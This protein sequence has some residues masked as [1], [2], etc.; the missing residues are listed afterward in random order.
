MLMLVL[1][2]GGLWTGC[3]TLNLPFAKLGKTFT[4]EPEPSGTRSSE[5]NRL[6][7]LFSPKT[8]NTR[9]APIDPDLDFAKNQFNQGE[10]EIA[11]FYL[12]KTLIGNPENSEALG[13]LPWAYFYQKRYTKALRAFEHNHAFDRKDPAALIGMGWCYFIMTKYQQSLD[14][15]TRAER[16]AVAVYEA[17]KGKGFTYLKQKRLDKAKEEF[18]KIYSKSELEQL[19][20]V[21]DRWQS[22]NQWGL[23]DIVP[24]APDSLSLFTLPV[25]HPRY[26]STL[27]GLI[28][29]NDPAVNRA[30]ALYRK[31]SYAKALQAFLALPPSPAHSLDRMNGLAWS[32]LKTKKIKIAERIFKTLLNTHPKFTGAVKGLAKVHGLKQRKASFA[33]YY[34]GLG[35]LRIAEDKFKALADEFPGWPYPRIQLGAIQ[36]RKKNYDAASHYYQK[37]RELDPNHPG[38]RQGLEEV[39][40][41]LHPSLYE[42]G[43][44]LQ[45]G[46]FKKAARIYF[47][48]L[49][50]HPPPQ[51][52]GRT[53][54]H[55]YNGLGWSQFQK[56]HYRLA[57]EKF[58]RAM[59]HPDFRIEAARGMGHSY[60]ALKDYNQA[61]KYLQMV[62]TARPGDR[63]IGY[64]LDESV[65]RGWKQKPAREYFQRELKNHPLRASPYMGLGWIHYRSGDPDLAVE[66]FLKSISLDPNLALSDP[67]IKMLKSERFGWQVFNRMGWAFYRRDDLEKSLE[68]FE[69]SLK[70]QPDKSEARKGIGYILFR[71]ERY[72]EAAGYLKQALSI[73]P[74]PEPV[75]EAMPDASRDGMIKIPTTART[76]LGRAF[77]RLG[78]YREA[79]TW[80]LQELALHPDR[81][82]AYDGLGWTH[83]K[84]N[85]LAESRVAFTTALKLE[86]LNILSNKGLAQLK[87]QIALQSLPTINTPPIPKLAKTPG[88][89]TVGPN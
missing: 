39:Q 43:Q 49:E 57:I 71:K 15:F 67:F 26:R 35:K 8:E 76:K 13:L 80:F 40:K 12:K 19:L 50:D 66:F 25:E 24:S 52:L 63:E 36:L 84:L 22:D 29:K 38:V 72:V 58:Q 81:I 4:P 54:A 27:W 23:I 79:V 1:P 34:F 2:L 70:E 44:A 73:N 86:P 68:M 75:V 11:E 42:A 7:S 33:Q 83:L 45:K 16:W 88:P 30:W 61:A 85:R 60:Y 53:Q 3:S 64:K 47:E 37:A 46:D 28:T 89:E 69:L 87:Q 20:A 74:D 48:Y 17:H 62:F 5:L 77:Y 55:A 31:G 14:T 56:G 51:P 9:R 41:F 78:H 59:V 10:F 65:L 21:W 32:Y 82:D 18:L 6:K